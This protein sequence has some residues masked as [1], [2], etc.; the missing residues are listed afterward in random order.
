MIMEK[1]SIF[2][3]YSSK[4]RETAEVIQQQLESSGFDIWRDKTRLETDWSREIAQALADSDVLCLLWSKQAKD[5]EWVQH[6]WLTARALEKTI[7]PCRLPAAPK[8]PK[9]LH[10]LQEVNLENTDKGSQDLVGRLNG[11]ND[12][13]V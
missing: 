10:N 2:I 4:D 11:K 13:T 8:L 6:E 1:P 12:F 9:P 5:S 3:S 7:I